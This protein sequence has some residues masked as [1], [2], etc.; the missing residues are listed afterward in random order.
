[1]NNHVLMNMTATNLVGATNDSGPDPLYLLGLEDAIVMAKEK[2]LIAIE[3]RRSND[4]S[5]DLLRWILRDFEDIEQLVRSTK[6]SV[7]EHD[8]E[9]VPELGNA[10]EKGEL[11]RRSP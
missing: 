10:L 5:V 4:V 1:M 6:A 9:E 2:V 8:D 7:D 3:M 11:R